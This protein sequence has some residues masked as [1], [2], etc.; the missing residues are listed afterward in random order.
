MKLLTFFA[1]RFVAGETMDKAIKAVKKLN[2]RNITATL[3]ILGEDV[4]KKEDAERFAEYYINLLDAIE[5]SGVDSNV[6]LKLTMTGLRIDEKFCFENTEKIIKHAKK[7]NNFVRVDMEGS[8]VTDV[9]LDVFRKLYKKYPKNVGIV[10]Q[11]MLHRCEDDVKEM[12]KLKARVRI[13]KGAYKEPTDIAW[14]KMDDIRDNFMKMTKLLI[15]K[16][17]YPG[18]ATHDDKMIQATLDYVKENKI[19]NDKYEFQLLY[20]INRAAQEKLAE[21][22]YNVRIYVP[23]G[24][25]WFPYFY[26]R[27][28]ERKENVFFIVKH[29]FRK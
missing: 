23:Y 2:E 24:T 7:L 3:D 4:H 17:N 5:E 18:I 26:R 20:G 10:L 1:R 21:E 16:G 15:E 25:H 27:L 8:D 19:K 12:N 11:A 22:G 28:R 14:K 9:T 29:F 13:C 6:S